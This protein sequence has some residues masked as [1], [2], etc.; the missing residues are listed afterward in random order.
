VLII[1]PG[2]ARISEGEIAIITKAVRNGTGLLSYFDNSVMNTDNE[3]RESDG[4]P[5]LG[6]SE[7]LGLDLVSGRGKYIFPVS[8]HHEVVTASDP[9]DPVWRGVDLNGT[10]LPDGSPVPSFTSYN[11]RTRPGSGTSRKTR[12]ETA[13]AEV[14]ART[15]GHYEY[16]A[17]RSEGDI[18][19]SLNSMGKGRAAYIAYESLPPTGAFGLIPTDMLF[20]RAF[21]A[22]IIR[23]ISPSPVPRVMQMP[24]GVSNLVLRLDDAGTDDGFKGEWGDPYYDT[25]RVL[26][27]SPYPLAVAVETDKISTPLGEERLREW[28]AAGHVIVCHTRGRGSMNMDETE[29]VEDLEESREKLERVLGHPVVMWSVPGSYHLTTEN[30]MSLVAKAGYELSGEW[31]SLIADFICPDACPVYPYIV[32][33]QELGVYIDV[34]TASGWPAIKRDFNCMI[35]DELTNLAKATDIPCMI[36]FVTHVPQGQPGYIKDW[37]AFMKDVTVRLERGAIRVSMLAEQLAWAKA[38]EGLSLESR[39]GGEEL[40]IT[41]RNRNTFPVIDTAIDCGA[42]ILSADCDKGIL[43]ITDASKIILR[44]ISGDTD[45]IIKAVYKGAEV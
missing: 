10:D 17:H 16:W 27:A 25:N 26:E 44:E 3:Q 42:D 18:F 29:Q 41:L 8:V 4:S 1:P 24:G 33:H 28:E 31:V 9:N 40:T 23:K 15:R 30:T 7:V 32:H 21:L 5:S 2:T 14:L 37:K 12:T 39:A 11:I 45:V 20:Y 22:N 19:L 6:L 35:L 36:E 34:I 13:S 43:K 38:K